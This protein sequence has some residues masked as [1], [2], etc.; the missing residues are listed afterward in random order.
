MKTQNMSEEKRLPGRNKSEIDQFSE[1]CHVYDHVAAQQQEALTG[2]IQQK[3]MIRAKR[4]VGM[5]I[6]L[7]EDLMLDVNKIETL[8]KRLKTKVSNNILL[9]GTVIDESTM[10][11]DGLLGHSLSEYEDC[12]KL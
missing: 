5:M 11:E 3:A 12:L 9:E 7:Q 6:A 1:V 2:N 4:N 8:V 10:G